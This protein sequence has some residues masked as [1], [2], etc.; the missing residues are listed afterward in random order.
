MG[1]RAVALLEEGRMAADFSH[2]VEDSWMRVGEVVDEYGCVAGLDERDGGV[3]ADVSE[4]SREEDFFCIHG[5]IVTSYKVRKVRKNWASVRWLAVEL[6]EKRRDKEA[7]RGR[8][9]RILTGGKERG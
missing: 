1:T 9:E 5:S 6:Q 2:V 8:S 4:A 7:R 3:R